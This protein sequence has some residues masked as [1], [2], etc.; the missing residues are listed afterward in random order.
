MHEHSSFDD[1]ERIRQALGI[2]EVLGSYLELRRQGSAYAAVCP[3]HDDNRPSLQVNPARQSWKCWVCDIGGDIFSFIMRRENVEF[4]E[5][6]RILADMAGIQLTR[7]TSAKSMP[8]DPGDKPT[9]YKAMAWV[10]SQYHQFLKQSDQAQVARDYLQ[11]RGIQESAIDAFKIGYVPDQFTWLIDR[12]RGSGFSDHVLQAIG[13]LKISERSKRFYDFFRGRIMFPIRDRFNR[14]IAVGGRI[15]PAIAKLL[16]EKH[17]DPPAK[18]I[19]SPETKL[20]SKSDQ[21]YGLNLMRDAIAKSRHLVVVEGYTDVI[22]AWQAGLDNVVAV[23]GTALGQRHIRMIRPFADRVTLVLDGDDAGKRRANEVLELF[24]TADVDL[25]IL[26]L[27]DDTDPFDFLS[28][29]DAGTFRQ[30][31][32][33]AADAIDHKINVE[34]AGIDL[35]RDTH[36]SHQALE[37]IL[38]TIA[39]S[40][41]QMTSRSQTRLREQQLLARLSRVF[42]VEISQLKQRLTDN[43]RTGYRHDKQRGGDSRSGGVHKKPMMLALTQKDNELIQMVLE[44][45]EIFPKVFEKITVE[46]LDDPVAR[47]IFQSF[48][49]CYQSGKSVGFESLMTEIEDLDLKSQINRLDE[50][51]QL[52]AESS[53]ADI[54]TRLEQL[55]QAFDR[56]REQLGVRQA[57]SKLQD[58][59]ADEEQD[60]IFKALSEQALHKHGKSPDDRATQD[61]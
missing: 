3:W 56:D 23:L 52:K 49:D 40:P 38:T 4:G 39:K 14:P 43:R 34:T 19:N 24:V 44:A 48:C 13:M 28:S 17:G 42:Q 5:A 35:L 54:E 27:P 22:A 6:M 46:Q 59:S 1:K 26:T 53:S 58:P 32:D 2:E 20:F 11:E 51:A 9:L 60:E 47:K 41:R 29:S 12:A 31:V 61:R 7:H 33:E 37:N 16:E 18:Y 36:K 30:M 45:P 57:I 15:L 55:L 25:R 50:V 10:E 21:L 8:G